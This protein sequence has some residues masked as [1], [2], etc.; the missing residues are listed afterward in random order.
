MRK[1]NIF[2]QFGLVVVLLAG[3]TTKFIYESPEVKQPE[4]TGIAF[5]YTKVEDGRDDRKIDHIYENKNPLQ[6]IVKIIEVEVRST[7]LFEKV[8]LIPEDKMDNDAYLKENDVEFLMRPF[9][10]EF[11]WTV[12][13]YDAKVGGAFVAGLFGGLI[14]GIIYGS[15]R[16]DVY[17]DTVLKIQ[18]IDIGS[19]KLLIDKE[20]VGHWTERKAIL[21][22]DS[23]ETKATVAGDSLKVVMEEFKVDLVEA[24]ESRAIK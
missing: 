16:T 22:C 6:D 7:G 3:C 21:S 17:G 14:G 9:L 13:N 23:A 1:L 10:K 18:L 8:L 5:A 11:K 2:I 12:P 4:P 19:G 20:Y 24:V 15:F